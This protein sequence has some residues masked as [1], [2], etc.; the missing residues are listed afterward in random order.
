MDP[1]PAGPATNFYPQLLAEMARTDRFSYAD[2]NLNELCPQVKP[3]KIE[4][5]LRTWWTKA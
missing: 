2:A 3:M 1:N 4:E 5:F